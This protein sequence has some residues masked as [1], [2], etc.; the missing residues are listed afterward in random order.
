VYNLVYKTQGCARMAA[1]TGLVVQTIRVVLRMASHK[2]RLVA[3][4]QPRCSLATPMLKMPQFL[5]LRVVPSHL[6][7]HLLPPTSP[8]RV[9]ASVH[10]IQ[11]YIVNFAITDQGWLNQ[12][13]SHQPVRS[14]QTLAFEA[15]EVTDTAD[16]PTADSGTAM[17]ER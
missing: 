11:N 8:P 10:L 14:D 1:G 16:G 12:Q 7:L 4:W 17:A 9:L 6:P 2:I 3:I 5:P 13:L 15:P